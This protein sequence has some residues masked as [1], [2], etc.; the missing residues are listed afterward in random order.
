MTTEYPIAYV[1]D[2]TPNQQ[3]PGATI[4]QIACPLCGGRH[5]HGGR[6]SEGDPGARSAHCH[7]TRSDGLAAYY[8]R[9]TTP[10]HAAA[11]REAVDSLRC[12]SLTASGQPCRAKPRRGLGVP[13]CARH[14]SKDRRN[15][16]ERTYYQEG[17]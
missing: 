5:Q 12:T 3:F 16:P 7:G 10:K 6:P 14:I 8:V 11:L 1:I 2:E 9:R 4:V 13:L 15:V 17:I